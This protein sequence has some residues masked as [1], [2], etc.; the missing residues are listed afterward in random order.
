MH[1]LPKP[2]FMFASFFVCASK[3]KRRIQPKMGLRRGRCHPPTLAS[4]DA[5]WLL[6]RPHAVSTLHFEYAPAQ[7]LIRHVVCECGGSTS[8]AEVAHKVLQYCYITLMHLL[9]VLRYNVEYLWTV[10]TTLL[11]LDKWYEKLLE[12]C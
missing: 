7:I 8:S 4:S 10:G 11:V 5:G 2:V 1:A 9:Y 12:R 3:Y 6:G